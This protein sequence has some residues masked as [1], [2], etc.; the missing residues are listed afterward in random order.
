MQREI[1]VHTRQE[2]YRF[3]GIYWEGPYVGAFF[4]DD[5]KGE[6]I[7]TGQQP[8]LENT[9]DLSEWQVWIEKGDGDIVLSTTPSFDPFVGTATPGDAEDYPVRLTN[10]KNMN[11]EVMLREEVE[12]IFELHGKEKI[13]IQSLITDL[14]NRDMHSVFVL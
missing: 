14:N 13:L 10:L 5:E 9:T 4:R 2:G 6:R 11:L 7:I 1:K 3:D 12:F 8:R